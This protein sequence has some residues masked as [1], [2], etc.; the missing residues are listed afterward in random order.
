MMKK[1]FVTLAVFVFFS[2]PVSAPA[3]KVIFAS[4]EWPPYVFTEN[5]QAA[6]F[7]TEIVLELCKRLNIE[8]EIQVLPWARALAYTEKGKADAIFSARRT[9]ERDKF[10]LCPSEPIM[11][12]KTVI[13]ALK[14]SGI[15][16]NK[17]HDLKDK[18]VGVVRG[19]TYTPEF[20]KY[21]GMKQ[22]VCD[23]DAQLVKMFGAKR[24]LLAAGSDE[25]TIKYLCKKAGIEAEVVYV[26]SEEPSYIG[27]SKAAGEE[28]SKALADKFGEALRKL[29][30]EGFIEKV[31]SKYF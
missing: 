28:K 13:M 2:L 4:S 16:I 26:L 15:K 27:F 14:G 5:G 22:T 20:D 3:E 17:L 11:I 6:G 10:M 12:E 19:Y 23:D 30:E 25:G 7:H 31:Q 18:N 24:I 8:P 21:Q 1:L 9:E 29:K